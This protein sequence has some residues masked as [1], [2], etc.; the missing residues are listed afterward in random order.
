MDLKTPEIKSPRWKGWATPILGALTVPRDWRYLRE[1]YRAN[2]YTGDKFRQCLAWL[3]ENR[4]IRSRYKDET[5]LWFRT[6]A[7]ARLATELQVPLPKREF[8]RDTLRQ[9]GPRV[10]LGDL[11]FHTVAEALG[12]DGGVID[13][14]AARNLR[15]DLALLRRDGVLGE[16]PLLVDRRLDERGDKRLLES[17]IL[18]VAEENLSEAELIVPVEEAH[19]SFEGPPEVEEVEQQMDFG[20]RKAA[21]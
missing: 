19:G 20:L 7:G 8:G 1:W 13:E 5:I 14:Q 2:R 6:E 11:R 12:E 4:L 17:G 18:S 15:D 10:P 3:E 9:R 16:E 21:S